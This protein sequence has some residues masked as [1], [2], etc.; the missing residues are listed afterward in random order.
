ME[1]AAWGTGDLTE[2]GGGK[3]L[4]SSSSISVASVETALP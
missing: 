2:S 4:P 3:S 1:G